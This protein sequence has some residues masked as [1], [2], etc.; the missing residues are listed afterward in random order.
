[1]KQTSRRCSMHAL[2]Y[3]SN[4]K[5]SATD[6]CFVVV[7]YMSI[8]SQREKEK[9][10]QIFITEM[11]YLSCL[12][13]VHGCRTKNIVGQRVWREAK[14][15]RILNRSTRKRCRGSRGVAGE[16][17][18]DT[19]GTR[20]SPRSQ[21]QLAVGRHHPP[22]SLSSRICCRTGPSSCPACFVLP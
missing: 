12:E 1:M 17:Q 8:V 20:A 14:P 13:P 6:L 9:I 15:H 22:A 2:I 7:Q 16:I 5:P 18:E 19:I 10:S 3:V 21:G 11:H 4:K